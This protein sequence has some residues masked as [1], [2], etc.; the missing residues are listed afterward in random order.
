MVQ[1]AH[2]LPLA[3]QIIVLDKDGQLVQTGNF[4]NLNACEGYIRSLSIQK[5]IFE[6][7]SSPVSIF[8]GPKDIK[9]QKQPSKKIPP[10]SNE[11]KVIGTQDKGTYRF[12]FG[13]IGVL[14]IGILVAAVVLLSF[15]T[16]FQRKCC[17]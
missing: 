17:T 2:H 13:P 1:K 10:N 11:T 5:S 12:Y 6:I 7:E 4:H 9:E 8:P 15:A 14:R 16:R 3:D